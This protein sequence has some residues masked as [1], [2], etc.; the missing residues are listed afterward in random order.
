MG[1]QIAVTP[2]QMASAVSSI[3]NGGLLVEPRVVRAFLGSGRREPV[4]P[5]TL[6]RT[7]SPETAAT[8]TGIMEEVVTRGT[9]KAAQIGG[10]TIAGKTGTAA[11][12]VNLRYSTSDYNASF[13]GFVPSR[14]PVLTIIVVIDSP[15]VNGHTGGAVSAPI[16]QRIA[17]ASLRHLG[18]GPTIG[19]PSP[20]LVARHA[21]EHVDAA[22]VAVRTPA[23]TGAPA[24]H[25]AA[26]T[27]PDLRGLS[28]REA[29]RTLTSLGMTARISGDGL[30]V[31][32]TPAPG[33]LLQ[34]GAGSQLELARRPLAARESRPARPAPVTGGAPE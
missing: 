9:A 6:R 10:Y 1:Y 21:P 12:L 33:A 31:R 23:V 17:E 19:A 2:L 29:L 14:K 26:G 34:T 28:A 27:M 15:H 22:P 24:E 13:V 32:Q 20:V 8:L 3:A 16:F 4:A 30:V 11:K 18:V 25:A 7:V 5:R